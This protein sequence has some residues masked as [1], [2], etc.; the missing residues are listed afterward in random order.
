MRNKHLH[1]SIK[2][3]IEFRLNT[4]EEAEY[5]RRRKPAPLQLCK[6]EYFGVQPRH[7][8]PWNDE[9]E[10]LYVEY[11]KKE[12]EK[13]ETLMEEYN[14]FVKGYDAVKKMPWSFW[15]KQLSFNGF[16]SV[17]DNQQIFNGLPRPLATYLKLKFNSPF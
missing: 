10:Q 7:L 9:V 3:E 12:T 4:E 17:Y 16:R 5:K 1:N 11:V 8:V 2:K 15:E 6:R 13:H 14:E